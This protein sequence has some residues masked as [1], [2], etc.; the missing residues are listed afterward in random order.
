MSNYDSPGFRPPFPGG[1]FDPNGDAMTAGGSPGAGD[2]AGAL[3]REGEK[4]PKY[5]SLTDPLIVGPQSSTYSADTVHVSPTDVNTADQAQLY[6][7][8][9]G[10]PPYTSGD[11]A[12]TAAGTGVP[13]GAGN[14]NAP[15][16]NAGGRGAR[17]QGGRR[18]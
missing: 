11:I 1:A 13:R 8:G 10:W 16:P 12:R 9:A 18:D 17:E 2:V 3:A 7:P 14:P 6:A 4:L 5:N 15:H